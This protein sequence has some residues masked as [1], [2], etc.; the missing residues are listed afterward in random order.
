MEGMGDGEYSAEKL[1]SGWNCGNAFGYT[2]ILRDESNRSG[3][4]HLPAEQLHNAWRWNYLRSQVQ[5]RFGETKFVP[6]IM[7]M[8]LGGST[9]T[10]AVWPDAIPIVIT[11]VDY[12]CVPRKELAPTKFFRKK[13]DTTFVAWDIA[14]PVLLQ[15]GTQNE[16]GSICL[17]YMTP[18]PDVV[19][20]VQSLTPEK[21]VVT[22]LSADRVLDREIYE[23]SII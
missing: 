6:R 14:L 13:E 23:R 20:F 17:N 21:R 7:F 12:L 18:P 10:A 19:K 8:K 15:H 1:F 5:A 11:N 3:M 9:V 22:G 16:D 4:F 2:S